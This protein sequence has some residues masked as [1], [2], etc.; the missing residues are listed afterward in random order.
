MFVE[1]LQ[2]THPF[3]GIFGD[4]DDA[5]DFYE[6]VRC[7][8]LHEARTRNNWTISSRR[9]TGP[10]IDVKAKVIYRNDLQDTFMEFADWYGAQLTKNKDYQDAFIRKFDSLCID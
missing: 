8:L 3:D 7:A 4:E 9:A 1:F 2:K 10:C 5:W 6:S